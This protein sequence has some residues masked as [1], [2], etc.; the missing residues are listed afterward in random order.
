MTAKAKIACFTSFNRAYLPRARVLYSTLKELHPEVE[1]FALFV[2]E[3][4]DRQ[5]TKALAGCFDHLVLAKDIGYPNF[6]SWMFGHDVIEACT[7]VKGQFCLYLSKL[8][9]TRIVYLDPD[10]AVLN[11]LVPIFDALND[12]A[13]LLTPHQLDPDDA[14][15]L[16]L[17]NEVCS[18]RCGTFNLG[19]LAI[20]I[21]RADGWR[22]ATWW[23][24]R[25]NS[26]CRDDRKLGLF[27]DQKWCDLVPAFFPDHK[28]LRDPGCNVA[29]WNL[30]RRD[31]AISI[32]GVTAN[33]SPIRFFHFSKIGAVGR[34]MLEKNA[35]TPMPA[36][37]LALW[38]DRCLM[39]KSDIGLLGPWAYGCFEDG[40]DIPSSA[41]K[42]YRDRADLQ[43]GFRDPF[44]GGE[45]S[46]SKWFRNQAVGS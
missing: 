45:H 13:I 40:T 32:D 17:D 3:V 20:N 18:L 33:G 38:Y 7:A 19:F 30:S 46:F 34:V 22:F 44:R 29:S 8:G 2:D 11:S 1:F 10:I 16:V 36:L 5:M 4:P 25:L 41:R 6:R 12:S 9:F 27:T 43:M 24:A 14:D 42:L 15:T 26:F 23:A 39:E 35:R 28:I 37:E 31:L 21:E